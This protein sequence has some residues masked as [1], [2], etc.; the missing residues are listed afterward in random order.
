MN[1]TPEKTIIEINGVKLEVDLRT[2]RR[3]ENITVG[4]RVKVLAKQYDGYIVKHGVVIGFEPFEN[5]PTIII[6]TLELSY[7]DAKLGFLYYN[8]AT[9]D[10]EVVVSTDDDHAAVDKQQ[11][12]DFIDREI[13]KRDTEIMELQNRK[14]YFLK[15]FNSYWESADQSSVSAA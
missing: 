15:K 12:L 5:L 2:A 1:Q 14:Q 10:T 4:S 11:V 13:T 3:V 8:S 7:A 9:K 6:A